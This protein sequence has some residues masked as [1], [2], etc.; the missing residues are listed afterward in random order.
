M[1]RPRPG[2]ALTTGLG[3]ILVGIFFINLSGQYDGFVKGLGLGAG[4]ALVIIGVVV[5]SPLVKENFGRPPSANEEVTEVGTEGVAEGDW[6]P[7]RD[8]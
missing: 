3:S 8:G 1:W 6:L 7:R 2:T 5:L 4:F